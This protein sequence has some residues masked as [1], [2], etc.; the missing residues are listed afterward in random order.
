MSV[1]REIRTDAGLVIGFGAGI[2]ER[3]DFSIDLQECSTGQNFV[4]DPVGTL[5]TRRPVQDLVATAPNSGTISG[6]LQLIKRDDS[7]TQ[8]VVSD[9][10]IYK[11]N[12]ASVF[13]DVTPPL[14]TDGATNPRIRESYWSLD[15]YLVLTDI[16]LINTVYKWDGST[17]ARLPVGLETSTVTNLDSLICSGGTATATSTSAHGF[18]T[19][20]LVTISSATPAN[21]NGQFEI[22][23]TDSVTFTYSM[24]CT[25]SPAG[26]SYQAHKGRTVKAKYSVV[27]NNRVWLF[28]VEV[29]GTAYPHLGLVSAFEDPTLYDNETRAKDTGLT[30]NEA[31]YITSPDLKPINGAVSFYDRLVLSTVNGKIFGLLGD[32]ATDYEFKD[33]YPGSSGLGDEPI[34]NVGNDLIYFRRGKAV[35]SL[36]ATDTYG[37]V[38]TDDLSWWIPT[39]AKT[40]S[41]PIVVYDQSQQNVYFFDADLEGVLVY[42]KEFAYSPKFL[43]QRLS[44]WS[45]YTTLMD[46][47]FVTKCAVQIRPSTSTNTTVYWGDNAGKIYN[48][49]GA[50]LSGDAGSFKI[51]TSRKTRVI[52]ELNTGD[53]LMV[54]RLEYKR[55]F[56]ATVDLVFAWLDEL[57]Q[58][59]VTLDLKAPIEFASAAFWGGSIYW[60]ATGTDANYWGAGQNVSDSEQRSTMG[61]SVPGKGTGFVLTVQV[62][63][64]DQFII[65]RVYV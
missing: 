7:Q 1:K 58:E 36:L 59:T 21:Y 10:K 49:N 51:N 9:E 13:S 56:S 17:V 25:S 29:D 55:N 27:H 64:I 5:L 16:D 6:L 18:V 37:D 61:F 2:N 45:K 8:L 54:G 14:F 40:M 28:N 12:G 38:S 4:L 53:E 30:G 52:T 35:E 57:H 63:D 46:N 62:S 24:N 43:E 3:D 42:D 22:T 23:V 48:I 34:V 26:G 20:D 44:P 47:K 50:G 60:G 32:D 19:G 39:S 33:F 65:S 41:N 31:F 11:W 15:D